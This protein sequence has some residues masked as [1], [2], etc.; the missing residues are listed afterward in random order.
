MSTL[1][2]IPLKKIDGTPTTLA[3]YAGKVLLLVN[4]ASLCNLTPQYDGLQKLYDTYHRRGFQVLGFPANDFL[5]QEPGT[6]Q[7]IAKFCTTSFNIQFPMFEKIS[8]AGD[9]QHELYQ[10]LTTA[11]PVAQVA[12]PAFRADLES[13]GTKYPLP[14]ILWNFEKFL[15]NR[16][17]QV[18]ARFSP[19]MLPTD[20][21]I[22][23][24]IEAALPPL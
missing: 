7:E 11:Q 20:Q 19:E 5:N 9:S 22:L 24:A 12:D 2:D 4:T 10:L 17:G 13:Y 16:R 23:T 8:V 21:R 18:V 6:N 15:V 14:G 3:E 1:Y